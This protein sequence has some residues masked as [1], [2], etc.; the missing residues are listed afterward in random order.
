MRAW[1]WLVVVALSPQAVHA[2]LSSNFRISAQVE[3]GCLVNA[4]EPDA[5]LGVLGTL[6]FGLH[7]SLSTATVQA[8]LFRDA[9]IVLACTPGTQL[10]MRVDGG[11]H[12]DGGRRLQR[13]PSSLLAY[14]IYRQPDC[15]DEI[16]VGVDIALDT[17]SAPDD[18][19]IP[20]HGCVAL[21]GNAAA[22]TYQDTLVV[23]LAW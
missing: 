14:R 19:A 3:P 22:G 1:T 21:P 9:G 23:T 4:S 16:A 20:I 15:I 10:V 13:D 5:S 7:S 17:T 2:E 18:I 12:F 11:Q 8:A 6:D